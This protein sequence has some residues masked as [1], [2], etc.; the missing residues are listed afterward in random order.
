MKNT[1]RVIVIDAFVTAVVLIGACLIV[2]AMLR[3]RKHPGGHELLGVRL[4]V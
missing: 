4:P 3:A 1:A 2:I